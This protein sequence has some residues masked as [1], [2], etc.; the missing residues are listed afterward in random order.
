MN[1]WFIKVWQRVWS[2]FQKKRPTRLH[3]VYRLQLERW[4]RELRKDKWGQ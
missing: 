3:P 1:L 4:G 2:M